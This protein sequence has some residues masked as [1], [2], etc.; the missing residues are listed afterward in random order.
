MIFKI[1]E[2]MVTQKSRL[3]KFLIN[4]G[5]APTL[6]KACLSPVWGPAG[7]REIFILARKKEQNGN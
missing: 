6:E 4:R 5:I 2:Y 7:N 3:D 1:T